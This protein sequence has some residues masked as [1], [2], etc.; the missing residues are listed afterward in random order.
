MFTLDVSDDFAF[1]DMVR[2][3]MQPQ[4]PPAVDIRSVL[5]SEWECCREKCAIPPGDRIAI[6]VGSRKIPD[7]PQIVTFVVNRLKQA[8]AEPFIIPAMGSHGGGTAQGQIAILTKQGIVESVVGAPVRATMDVVV[9]GRVEGIPVYMDRLAHEADGL[10]LINRVKPHTDFTGP[11]ESGV[12]KM[13]AIGLGNR[14]GAGLDP[15]VIGG[16]GTCVW[17]D[18]RPVPEITRIFVRDLS[19]ATQGNAMGLGRLDVATEKLVNKIDMQTTAV[20]AITACC[21]EDCKIPLTL[22]TEKQAVAAALLTLWAY[23]LNDLKVV[24]IRNTRDLARMM[25]SKGCLPELADRKD[26]CMVSTGSPMTFDRT[27]HLAAAL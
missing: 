7:L 18:D 11:V 19:V 25:V 20:N 8:G 9:S 3:Q 15:N 14:T 26:I 6:G 5:A 21:P 27:G 13:L 12:I 4:I 23:T 22:A 10:V 16:K 1:P 24:H 2:I 17:S